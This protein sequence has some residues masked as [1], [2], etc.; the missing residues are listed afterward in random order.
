MAYGI[1]ISGGFA[2]SPRFGA[3]APATGNN[4]LVNGNSYQTVATGAV[5]RLLNAVTTSD[6]L[7]GG[8]DGS[9]AASATI[10]IEKLS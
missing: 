9:F 5:V 3:E 2:V 8:F 4:V 1:G 6:I 10:S 7:A